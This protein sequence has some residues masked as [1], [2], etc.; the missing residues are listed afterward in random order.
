MPPPFRSCAGTSP[1]EQPCLLHG[2]V[3]VLQAAH[4]VVC[5]APA[6]V[7][8]CTSQARLK[9]PRQRG[10]VLALR[11]QGRGEGRAVSTHDMGSLHTC[12]PSAQSRKACFSSRCCQG[13]Q[14]PAGV[15][16]PLEDSHW[17]QWWR[18]LWCPSHSAALQV[19]RVAPL[20]PSRRPGTRGPWPCHTACRRRT[21]VETPKTV[22]GEKAAAA[23][24]NGGTHRSGMVPGVGRVPRSP[25]AVQRN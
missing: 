17:G 3:Q 22:A 2:F 9:Q 23:A 7:H 19:S 4:V 12:W 10:H 13:C 20:P 8:T 25:A 6:E 16:D 24:N 5:C 1:A 15:K 18:R 14:P 11:F 21:A